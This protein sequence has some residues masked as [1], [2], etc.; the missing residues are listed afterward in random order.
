MPVSYSPNARAAYRISCTRCGDAV[1]SANPF[2]REAV[3]TNGER[4]N[5]TF[6]WQSRTTSWY[7]RCKPCQRAIRAERQY[8]RR[9]VAGAS[10]H[11]LRLA[12]RFGV[13]FEC[14][15]PNTV[16]AQGVVN[17]LEAAGLSAST[18]RYSTA[19]RGGWVAKPDGSLAGRG[20][21]YGLEIVSPALSG[22]AGLDQIRTALAVLNAL[23]CTVNSS[24][25][26]HVHHDASDLTVDE[27]K[28]FARG[29]MTQRNLVDGLVSASRRVGGSIY[30]SPFG[31][32][33]LARVERATTLRQLQNI[34][35]E[36]YR[37]LN[38]LAYGKFGT[39]EIRQHQG[40]LNYAKIASWIKLGQAMIDAAIEQPE[41][42]TETHGRMSEFFAALGERLEDTA[43]TYLLGRTVE[44]GY[45]TA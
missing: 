16:T 31:E 9:H 5:D 41:A 38:L 17:A 25:G 26:T 33:D 14:I 3:D 22:Q 32:Y 7:S 37:S 13:E 29:W 1:Y 28:R 24:C 11:G 43:R 45:A 42:I 2:H 34:P 23:G 44:I 27:I 19:A 21:G 18:G 36:R 40:T 8:G 39:L 12:R 15:V 10:R 35:A 30:C 20:A 6:V 4:V